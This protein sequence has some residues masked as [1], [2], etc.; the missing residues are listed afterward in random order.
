MKITK[1]QIRKIILKE[2]IRSNVRRILAE[3]KVLRL[4]GDTTWEYKFDE[5]HWWTRKQGVNKWIS[6]KNNTAAAEILDDKLGKLVTKTDGVAKAADVTKTVSKSTKPA[7]V[8][9]FKTIDQT[10]LYNRLYRDLKNHNLCSV[11][12][13]N[14][15]HESKLN[16]N[17]CGDGGEYASD[18]SDRA[19]NVAGEGLKCSFGLWQYN[20]CTKT[21][22]G[23][24]YLNALNAGNKSDQEKLDLLADNEKVISYMIKTV[25]EKTGGTWKQEGTVEKWNEWFVKNIENPADHDKAIAQR[26]PDAKKIAAARVPSSS[27]I[28]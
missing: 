17:C 27:R 19:I 7:A 5:G 12:V 26:L 4:P 20:I 10:E 15:M 8:P 2:Q 28:S 14:A 16:Q 24:Q 21:S 18:R 13:A 22:M 6:L 25:K 9:S 1:N 3:E 23:T 11:I